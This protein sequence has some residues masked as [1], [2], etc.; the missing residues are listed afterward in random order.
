MFFSFNRLKERIRKKTFASLEKDIKVPFITPPENS[1]EADQYTTD[2]RIKIQINRAEMAGDHQEKGSLS[3]ESLEKYFRYEDDEYFAQND[4]IVPSTSYNIPRTDRFQF[5]GYTFKRVNADQTQNMA[6][7]PKRF[8]DGERPGTSKSATPPALKGAKASCG[9]RSK[10]SAQPQMTKGPDTGEKPCCSKPWSPQALKGAKAS[11][12]DRS[13]NSA[14]PQMT[15]GPDTGEKPCCSKPWSPQ[16]L[17]GA[18]ATGGDGG[19]KPAKSQAVQGLRQESKGYFPH[20]FNTPENEQYEGPLPPPEAYGV[21]HM[22]P[23]EQ[24]AFLKWHE[25]NKTKTFNLQRELAAYCQQDVNILVQACTKYR[26]E[27]MTLTKK[28]VKGKPPEKPL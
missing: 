12:G 19:K 4:P 25:E 23:S 18:K 16:A 26:H 11:C 22:M 14:Q 7:P 8:K 27:I 9:D 3:S 24:K 5:R 17:K 13:K 6:I 21:Q 2:L 28:R 10:N 1:T 15:K 20:Y